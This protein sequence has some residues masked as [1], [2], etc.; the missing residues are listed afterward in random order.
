MDPQAEPFLQFRM[1]GNKKGEAMTQSKIIGMVEFDELHVKLYFYYDLSIHSMHLPLQSSLKALC[2]SIQI[3]HTPEDT[4]SHFVAHI[5]RNRHHHCAKGNFAC[6][7]SLGS[8]GT[9]L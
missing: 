7:P 9:I 8:I 4:F 6:L 5:N 2:G 1:A 3:K